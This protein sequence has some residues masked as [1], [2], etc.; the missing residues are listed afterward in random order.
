MESEKTTQLIRTIICFTLFLIS[1]S[2]YSQTQRKSNN[3]IDNKLGFYF[4]FPNGEWFLASNNK[5]HNYKKLLESLTNKNEINKNDFELLYLFT[6]NDD[7]RL[8]NPYVGV[9]KINKGKG[10][11]EYFKNNLSNYNK[12]NIKDLN[13]KRVS[14]NLNKVFVDEENKIIGTLTSSKG[15]FTSSFYIFPSGNLIQ[16]NFSESTDGNWKSNYGTFKDKIINTIKYLK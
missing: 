9:L 12:I 7:E 16:F 2:F 11:F 8:L 10:S 14:F 13:S 3:I 15:V 6:K 1:I 4:N 5:K